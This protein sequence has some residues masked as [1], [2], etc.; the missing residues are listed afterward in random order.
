MSHLH[1]A[2]RVGKVEEALTA[3]AQ[4]DDVNAMNVHHA[5]ALMLAAHEGHLAVVDLLL[6]AGADVGLAHP[7]GRTAL[8]FAASK[9]YLKIVEA[10]VAHGADVNALSRGGCTPALE[11]AQFNHTGVV[12][13]LREQGTDMTRKDRQ[14]M[15]ADE[16]LADGG[17]MGR[18]AKQIPEYLASPSRRASEEKSVRKLMER[19]LS[20]DEFA[21]THGRRTLVWSYGQHPFD[22]PEVERWAKR[23]AEVLF[24]PGLLAECEERFLLGDELEDARRCR[25]RRARSAVRDEKRSLKAGL[26]DKET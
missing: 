16:W 23:V 9:G 18:S 4:G 5:S 13:F 25:E 11:A 2:A 15:I 6:D 8:H 3:L 17:V 12:A 10:L 22:D 20:A 26:T 19:G 24:T 7:N 1:W 21:A 14:D